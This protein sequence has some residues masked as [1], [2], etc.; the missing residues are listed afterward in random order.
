MRLEYSIFF[1]LSCSI[2]FNATIYNPFYYIQREIEISDQQFNEFLSLL[3]EQ[4]FKHFIYLRLSNI[5][6]NFICIRTATALIVWNFVCHICFKLNKF[7]F[8]CFHQ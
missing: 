4:S 8:T 3:R 2:V 6:I 1:Q 5:D 7:F